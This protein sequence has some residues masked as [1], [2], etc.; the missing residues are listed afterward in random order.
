MAILGPD[1]YVYATDLAEGYKVVL[2]EPEA[3]TESTEP[4]TMVMWYK[5]TGSANPYNDDQ[6]IWTWD[7]DVA[8]PY[9]QYLAVGGSNNIELGFYTSTG[10]AEFIT[11]PA[12]ITTD[13]VD[14]AWHFIA[15]RFD[16]D[17]EVTL[18][19]DTERVT[20]TEFLGW[21]LANVPLRGAGS[22]IG[23]AQGVTPPYHN[24]FGFYDFR[25]YLKE[26]DND[27]LDELYTDM[28]N[29]Q[30]NNTLPPV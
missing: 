15:V 10:G 1:G 11:N 12:Q 9:D 20:A 19:V 6:F 8:G 14:T 2:I 26:V 28:K 16:A 21:K 5:Y 30:G 7:N 25:L 23:T 22:E 24:G 4:F 13:L 3:D 27:G 17:G 29:N 18:Q